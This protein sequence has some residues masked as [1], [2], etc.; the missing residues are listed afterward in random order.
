MP[1]R[2]PPS[3][4]AAARLCGLLATLGSAPLAFTADQDSA[5]GSDIPNI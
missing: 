1:R 2:S 5:P 3:A 4:L